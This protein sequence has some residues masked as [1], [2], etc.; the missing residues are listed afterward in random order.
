LLHFIADIGAV[1]GL[2]SAD[3]S[4]FRRCFPLFSAAV[5]PPERTPLQWLAARSSRIFL[6]PGAGRDPSVN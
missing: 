1:Y 5:I 2:F 6:G 4:L 3:I